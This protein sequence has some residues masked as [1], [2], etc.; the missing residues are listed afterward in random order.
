M[1]AGRIIWALVTAGVLVVVAFSS[2]FT[3]PNQVL[4]YIPHNPIR[5]YSDS[6]FI[7]AN[8]VT[9]GIGTFS[10]PY[11]IEGWEIETSGFQYGIVIRDTIAHF[12]IRDV[13]VHSGDIELTGLV[14]DNVFN[15]TVSNSIIFG[16]GSPFG[17][18]PGANITVSNNEIKGGWYWGAGIGSSYNVTLI[19]NEITG[20]LGGM[21]VVNSTELIFNGNTIEGGN[22]PADFT[23]CDNVTFTWNN[24]SGFGPD[25]IALYDTTSM[26]IHHN[27]IVGQMSPQASDNLGLE[28]SWDD[29]YPS[30][31]NYWSEYNGTDLMNGPNQD[32]PGSDGIGDTPYVIDLDSQ[33]RYPLVSPSSPPPAR[34][35]SNILAELSGKNWENVTI[36]W[37]PSM[38]DGENYK[39]V[40]AYEVYRNLTYDRVGLGYQLIGTVPN[41][42][43]E[44]VDVT[45]GEGNPNTYFYQVCAIDVSS[46]T[47]C[48]WIQA[49]KFT[50]PLV[51]GINLV[52]MPVRPSNRSLESVFQTVSFDR[53]WIQQWEWSISS[54]E[55]KSYSISKPYD[56]ELSFGG[57]RGIWI[58]VTA[59]S[60]LT[61]A[62]NLPGSTISLRA[63]WNL[64]A[65]PSFNTTYTVADLKSVANVTRVEGFDP[66]SPPYYLRALGDGETFQTGYGYWI[67]TEE[68]VTWSVSLT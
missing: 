20:R 16:Y 30:G 51:K 25:A 18:G 54:Y 22:W 31:G 48:S 28:N 2:L 19:G 59:D 38:D 21:S 33:D 67:Y 4:A 26:V 10:D 56:D 47:V 6:D 35:P 24:V 3:I 8:G 23:Y 63:G 37:R 29:G 64:V 57:K 15:G 17:L 65:F 14:L 46:N 9:G 12:V 7:P 32:I 49:L 53:L 62:G 36:S 13:Y 39:S 61:V 11:I 58:S 5:I 50:R 34:E 40:V 44:F 1:R 68:K 41:G 60:N 55:W 43:S 66:A 45:A 42:T 52:S 27:S